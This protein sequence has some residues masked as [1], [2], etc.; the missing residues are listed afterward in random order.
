MK[1][2]LITWI[3]GNFETTPSVILI[4]YNET[5]GVPRMIEVF[6]FG[7][8]VLKTPIEGVRSVVSGSY[9]SESDEE[10]E[11]CLLIETNAASFEK[12]LKK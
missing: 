9:P 8:I 11:D 3:H 1:Y 12:L 10:S 6:R 2:D 4:E 5:G 7:K